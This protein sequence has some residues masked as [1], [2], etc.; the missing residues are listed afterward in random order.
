MSLL[1]AASLGPITVLA[2]ALALG[3]ASPP[4]SSGR[5]GFEYG[6]VRGTG[7]AAFIVGTLLSGQAVSAFGLDLI[8]WLQAF[9]LG[10]AALPRSWSRK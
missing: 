10:M 8:V 6:W 1:H 5:R 7:S 9:L 2:D 3:S 4:P